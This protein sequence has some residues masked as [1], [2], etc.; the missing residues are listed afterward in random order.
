MDLYN[1]ERI[2]KNQLED[3]KRIDLKTYEKITEFIKKLG[4]N[5]Y[6][7]GDRKVC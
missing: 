6:S 3:I 2:I 7:M 1:R 5:N 4:A